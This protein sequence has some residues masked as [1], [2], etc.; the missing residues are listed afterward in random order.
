M[1][2]RQVSDKDKARGENQPEAVVRK[3]RGEKKKS[4]TPLNMTSLG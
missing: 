2:H 1:S 3:K 4:G